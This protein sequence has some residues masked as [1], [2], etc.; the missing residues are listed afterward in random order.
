MMN[1]LIT[2]FQIVSGQPSVARVWTVFL[3]AGAIGFLL[4][5]LRFWFLL[6]VLMF[7]GAVVFGVIAAM[8]QPEM[9]AA[10]EQYAPGYARHVYAA[11]IISLLAPCLGAVLSWRSIRVPVQK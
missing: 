3:L 5:R 2:I 10:I 6:L 9:R 7:Q 1:L 4:C 11:I 8:R